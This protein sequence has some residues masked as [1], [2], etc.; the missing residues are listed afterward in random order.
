VGPLHAQRLAGDAMHGAMAP[1]AVRGL[2]VSEG[3]L[4]LKLARS[5]ATPGKRF[6]LP[7]ASSTGA[8]GPSATSTSSTPSA[9]TSSSSGA[10]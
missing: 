3:G 2:A 5:T 4:T 8:G 1:Q 7:S 9:C 6:D 10:T